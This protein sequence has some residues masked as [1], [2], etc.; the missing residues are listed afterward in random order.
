MYTLITFILL[1]N[2]QFF[3]GLAA[4]LQINKVRF[5]PEVKLGSYSTDMNQN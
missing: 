5:Q 3:A 1:R 4:L 2:T